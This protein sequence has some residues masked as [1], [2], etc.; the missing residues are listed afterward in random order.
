[1]LRFTTEPAKKLGKIAIISV[2]NTLLM[3]AGDSGKVAFWSISKNIQQKQLFEAQI[4]TS[5][6]TAGAISTDQLYA[7]TTSNDKT[8]KVFELKPKIALIRTL[9]LSLNPGQPPLTFRSCLFTSDSKRLITLSIQ[10]KI[11][12]Y[13]TEWNPQNGFLPIESFKV[14]D[15]PSCQL[16][17]DPIGRQYILGGN[18]GVIKVISAENYGSRYSQELFEMPVTG[19]SVQ[20]KD[21]VVVVGSADYSYHVIALPSGAGW[22]VW[23]VLAVIVAAIAALMV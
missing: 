6:V 19:V 17:L 2:D 3:T 4:H 13:V 5:E 10:A 12:S 22:R 18:N 9:S 15:H 20:A 14:H 8:C 23:F 16:V 1:V 7:C 11:G 21:R